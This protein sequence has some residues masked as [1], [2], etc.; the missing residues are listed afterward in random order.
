[1]TSTQRVLASHDRY[2]PSF[3]SS[4]AIDDS[5]PGDLDKYLAGLSTSESEPWTDED[6]DELLLSEREDGEMEIDE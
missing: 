2:D 5:I 6:D 1:M 4:F 3:Q